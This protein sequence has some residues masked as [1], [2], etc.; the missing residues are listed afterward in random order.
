LELEKIKRS[1]ASLESG[2]SLLN[3]YNRPLISKKKPGKNSDDEVE[4]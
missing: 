4:I 2:E 3:C 1:W